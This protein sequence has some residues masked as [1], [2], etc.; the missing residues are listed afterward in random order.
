MWSTTGQPTRSGANHFKP[1]YS[2]ARPSELLIE[3]QCYL[4]L[5]EE[6]DFEL[7]SVKLR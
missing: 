1:K 4:N 5:L 7:T 6:I 2:S 3:L